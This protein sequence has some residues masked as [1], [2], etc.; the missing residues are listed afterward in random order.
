MI[1]IAQHITSSQG[2]K[3]KQ[4]TAI[5]CRYQGKGWK[6]NTVS[7]VWKL[8]VRDARTLDTV[9]EEVSDWL[10]E[11]E[12]PCWTPWLLQTLPCYAAQPWPP[13]WLRHQGQEIPSQATKI[14][15]WRTAGRWRR[16]PRNR[17]VGDKTSIYTMLYLDLKYGFPLHSDYWE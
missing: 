1:T 4:M 12:A 9:V 10:A 5:T 16:P 15:W 11:A 14:L 6:W 13:P 3:M 8:P 7:C 17:E 2:S